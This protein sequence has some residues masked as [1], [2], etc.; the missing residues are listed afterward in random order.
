MPRII[1]R[2]SSTFI[3]TP[4]GAVWQVFDADH[5]ACGSIPH[6]DADV[7]AR[8]FVSADNAARVRIYRFGI[9]ESRSITAWRMLEQLERAMLGD[10]R[11]A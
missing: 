1:A 7:L 8:I 5:Q 6:N 4:S 2:H 9:G 11:A 3:V 10:D